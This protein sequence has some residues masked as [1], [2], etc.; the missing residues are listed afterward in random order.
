MNKQEKQEQQV[1]FLFATGFFCGPSRS[2]IPLPGGLTAWTCETI[3]KLHRLKKKFSKTLVLLPELPHNTPRRQLHL[4]EKV[5]EWLEN[6]WWFQ[7]KDSSMLKSCQFLNNK[8]W[9]QN[10]EPDFLLQR[11][12][13]FLVQ[14]TETSISVT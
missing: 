10:H 7:T 5:N 8:T 6:S 4:R 12:V 11:P 9:V 13:G 14:R 2:G 3:L 1:F